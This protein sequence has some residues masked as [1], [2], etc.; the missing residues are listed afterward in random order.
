MNRL[1]LETETPPGLPKYKLMEKEDNLRQ[2]CFSALP[3]HMP[4]RGGGS[5][6]SKM[7]L[8]CAGVVVCAVRLRSVLIQEICAGTRRVC[9]LPALLVDLQRQL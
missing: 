6:V 3:W 1:Q 4:S 8:C 9:C 2:M 7:V 5:G